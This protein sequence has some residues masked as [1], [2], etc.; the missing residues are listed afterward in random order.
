MVLFVVVKPDVFY[1]VGMLQHI[2]FFPGKTNYYNCTIFAK[3]ATGF[4][5]IS[6]VLPNRKLPFITSIVSIG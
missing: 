4:F 2:I 1:K 3:N 6:K 5:K